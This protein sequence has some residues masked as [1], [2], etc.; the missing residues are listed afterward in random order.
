MTSRDN[1]TVY[2]SSVR[3]DENR[4]RAAAIY[5]SDGRFGEQIDD[6]LHNGLKLPRCDRLV[7]P[8]ALPA[9]PATSLPSAKKR[10]FS[11]NCVS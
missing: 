5:C 9:W 8:G 3:F 4:I 7:V 2:K 1:A 10:A 11:S 6:F